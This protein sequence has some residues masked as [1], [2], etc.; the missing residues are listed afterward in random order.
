MIRSMFRGAS[1]ILPAALAAALLFSGFILG[2]YADGAMPAYYVL[3]PLVAALL[4]ALLLGL[5]AWVCFRAAA[6]VAAVISSAVVAFW[7]LV[8]P[9]G[10]LL[11]FVGSVLMLIA[12]V[13]RLR[14]RIDVLLSPQLSQLA[15]GVVAVFF[16]IGL[17]RAVGA[18]LAS[19]TPEPVIAAQ[20]TG[21]PNLHLVLLDGYP[22]ADTLR[23]EFGIDIGPFTTDLAARGFTVY[24]HAQTDRIWTDMTLL[25]LLEGTVEGVPMGVS[26]PDERRGIRQRL[27]GAA[28]PRTAQRAGYEWVVIDSPAGHV[29]FNGGRHIQHG[30]LNSYEERLLGESLLGPAIAAWWP[31]LPT[32]SLRDHL[33]ASLDSLIA[34]ADPHAHRL[35]LAHIF[36]PHT[37]FLW[38]AAGDPL[39]APSFWP[40][41]Q[42]FESQSF[43]TGL[44]ISEYAGGLRSHL[45]GL[46]A[47]VIDTLDAVISRDPDAVIVLFGDHGARYNIDQVQ[48]EWH[49]ALLAAR[50]PGYPQLFADNPSPTTILRALLDAYL[51]DRALAPVP[52]L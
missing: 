26:D 2:R 30:G 37:P 34:L 41:V 6:P 52:P 51:P 10:L 32:D 12:V 22:R 3:R 15:L 25:S 21:G 45:A 35:I 4:L 38:N 14:R 43:I 49:R 13:L 39:P 16:T 31:S 42:L 48:N 1:S 33:D 20:G 5:T 19:T 11:L 28:L 17:A 7:S 40:R 44:S 23:N 8:A 9:W 29:T 47:R 46:N 50:T 27:A 18:A 36:A 24:E